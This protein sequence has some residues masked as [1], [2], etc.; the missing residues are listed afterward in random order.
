MTQQVVLLLE[1]IFRR[2]KV[3][4]LGLIKGDYIIK[5]SFNDDAAAKSYEVCFDNA[6]QI[7]LQI[8]TIMKEWNI[9]RYL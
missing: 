6:P 3:A 9:D 2:F 1:H 8:Y 7:T 4:F 5:S